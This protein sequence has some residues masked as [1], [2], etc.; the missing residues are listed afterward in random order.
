VILGWQDKIPKLRYVFS[1]DIPHL[2]G[3]VMTAP[4]E[5]YD[6]G[7]LTVETLKSTDE[8]VA[9]LVSID[10]VVIYHAGDLNWWHWMG[11]TEQ[12]NREMEKLYKSQ[13]DQLKGR[14]IDLAF[15]PVDPRLEGS[16]CLGIGYL[17]RVADVRYAI[18]MHF[19]TETQIVDYLLRNP[20]SEPYRDQIVG[21][22]ERGDMV[23]LE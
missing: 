19:G 18:P 12:Y 20:A 7:D 4:N 5:T 14:K 23:V 1:D 15:V 17:M 10:G 21:L 16:Y 22:T 6:L 8:G 3:A 13:I 9:F 2:P 11:E